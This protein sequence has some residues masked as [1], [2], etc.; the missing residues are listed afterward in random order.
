MD[1]ALAARSA[2]VNMEAE[3]LLPPAFSFFIISVILC[4]K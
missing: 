2:G 1:M 3:L 4:F